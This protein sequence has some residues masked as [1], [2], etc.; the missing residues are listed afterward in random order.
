MESVLRQTQA[1]D[2]VTVL[3]LISL[4]CFAAAKYFY[5]KR[6]EDFIVLPVNNK[7]FALQGKDEEINHPFNII[8]FVAQVICLS[9]FINLLIIF[10]NPHFVGTH[11]FLFVQICTAYVVFVLIKFSIEK[12][13]GNVFSIDGIVNL[14][15]YQKLTYR[16]YLAI[17]IFVGNLL[18]Y[19]VLPT[20]KA[21]IIIFLGLLI[22]GNAFA[23]LN[24]F[25][26]MGN[27]FGRN[28]VYFILY[29]CAL[30]ITPYILLYYVVI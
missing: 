15:L 20:S 7:Y 18:F 11:K 25:K 30:E 19:Y 29:L 27:L 6:F 17:L 28:F 22:V 12:I 16:N 24:S 26:K 2:W 23:M 4:V 1:L 8:L 13:I 14:Y 21:G 5:A 9:L 10:Y 3:L